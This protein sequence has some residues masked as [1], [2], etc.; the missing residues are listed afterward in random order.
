M[1]YNEMSK[2]QQQQADKLATALVE[3]ITRPTE[4]RM[5]IELHTTFEQYKDDRD[6]LHHYY[7]VDG[8]QCT[9]DTYDMERNPSGKWFVCG[10]AATDH[11][12]RHACHLVGI[13]AVTTW[14]WQMIE[15]GKVRDIWAE[16][17]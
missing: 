1:K 13:G 11:P 5:I 10:E 12:H 17:Y 15:R 7:M 6:P 14:A 4:L 16:S 9:A 3:I 2:Q 8:A